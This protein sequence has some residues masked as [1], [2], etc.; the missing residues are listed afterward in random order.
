M[1]SIP[2]Q[3]VTDSKFIGSWGELVC[4]RNLNPINQTDGSPVLPEVQRIRL[5]DKKE[6]ESNFM[7]V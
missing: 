6:V 1:D 7:P 4:A 2:G 5:Y 3:E